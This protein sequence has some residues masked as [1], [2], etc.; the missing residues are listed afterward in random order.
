MNIVG[1]NKE[2]NYIVNGVFSIYETNGIPLDILFEQLRLNNYIPD[3]FQF[4][5][6]AVESGMDKNR[7]ISMLDSSISDSYGSEFRDNV[8]KWI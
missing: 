2:G 3:W 5:V 1:K 4:V 7:V 8:L 6:D